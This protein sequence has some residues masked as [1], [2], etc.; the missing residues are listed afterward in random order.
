MIK[1]VRFNN[2]SYCI[3]H[4]FVE[5]CNIFLINNGKLTIN[6]HNLSN[7]FLANKK[8]KTFDGCLVDDYFGIINL[9]FN[10]FIFFYS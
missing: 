2:G 10:F 3:I 6:F 4:F 5:T 7:H 1:I 8:F 9:D